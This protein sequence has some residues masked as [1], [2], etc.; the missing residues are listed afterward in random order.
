MPGWVSQS[1]FI[2]SWTECMNQPSILLLKDA[3]W[4]VAWGACNWSP[5][6]RAVGSL[7]AFNNVALPFQL[8]GLFL[9][10]LEW[11]LHLQ[12]AY[13]LQSCD[14][15][16]NPGEHL[17]TLHAAVERF[18]F[19]RDA[20]RLLSL[21]SSC[22]VHRRFHIWSARVTFWWVLKT[23]SHWPL[24]QEKVGNHLW[25]HFCFSRSCYVHTSEWQLGMI[26]DQK[27]LKVK[28]S[29]YLIRFQPDFH[30]FLNWDSFLVK[31]V[32]P[33]YTA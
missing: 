12:F 24:A 4:K 31:G 22:S 9:S 1:K 19:L 28:R 11:A 27:M 2:A 30:R 7:K 18:S 16:V 14:V 29:L 8:F 21:G 6:P 25:L 33:D 3:D 5:S 20:I 17:E 23:L 15:S 32:I 13:L 26:K 10:K